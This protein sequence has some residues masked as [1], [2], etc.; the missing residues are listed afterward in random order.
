MFIPVTPV[1]F[2]FKTLPK[3][4]IWFG[5]SGKNLIKLDVLN[6]T[7]FIYNDFLCFLNIRKFSMLCFEFCICQNKSIKERKD[8]NNFDFE[9]RNL[10]WLYI[11]HSM[12]W[13]E[14]LEIWEEKISWQ[15]FLWCLFTKTQVFVHL[16]FDYI[17]SILQLWLSLRSAN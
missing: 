6:D 3:I 16:E 15:I 10:F 14:N 4:E 11:R 9:S 12:P 13:C 1:I 2:R 8:R 5:E 17:I 7:N